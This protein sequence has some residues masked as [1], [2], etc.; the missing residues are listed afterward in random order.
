MPGCPHWLIY[1]AIGLL[2]IRNLFSHRVIVNLAT[3]TN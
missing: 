3:H 2:V 1:Q